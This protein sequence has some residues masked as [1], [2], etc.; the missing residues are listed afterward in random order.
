VTLY[1]VTEIIENSYLVEALSEHKAIKAVYD[2]TAGE[3]KNTDVHVT[4]AVELIEKA[5]LWEEDHV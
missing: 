5:D 4:K 2:N 1:R 3:P